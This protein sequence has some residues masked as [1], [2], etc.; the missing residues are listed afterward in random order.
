MVRG[1]QPTEAKLA[2]PPAQGD[3]EQA[4]WRYSNQALT[5]RELAA[6]PYSP[7]GIKMPSEEDYIR[8]RAWDDCG[9]PR[10]ESLPEAS[11]GEKPMEYPTLNPISPMRETIDDL[12][13]AK[14]ENERLQA[15]HEILK[16]RQENERLKAKLHSPVEPEDEVSINGHP[17]IRFEPSIFDAP[18]NTL[19]SEAE[20]TLK[21]R[22]QHVCGTHS[23]SRPKPQSI[24][25]MKRCRCNEHLDTP[26]PGK[27]FEESPAEEDSEDELSGSG[28]GYSRRGGAVAKLRNII[29]IVEDSCVMERRNEEDVLRARLVWIKYVCQQ[30]DVI[31]EEEVSAMRKRFEAIEVSNNDEYHEDRTDPPAYMANGRHYRRH[32]DLLTDKARHLE[33]VGLR[34]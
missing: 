27:R 26:Y 24:R 30:A 29:E 14:L 2:T 20:S 3:S 11:A 5:E 23:D 21:G 18:L 12:L 1:N 31:S 33:R 15:Q 22:Y 6:F 25:V 19:E 10:D 16:L 7:S 17:I 4:P 28:G 13:E 9:K 8:F 34:Y 32:P